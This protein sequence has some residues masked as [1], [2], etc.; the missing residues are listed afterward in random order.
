MTTET[1]SPPPRSAFVTVLAWTII[2][3]SA[4]VVPVSAIALLMILARSYGTDATDVAG[5]LSVVVAPPAALLAG[6]GL[7]RRR[8]WAWWA[9]AALLLLLIAANGQALLTAHGTTTTRRTADGVET[10]EMPPAPNRPSAPI[11]AVC[12]FVLVGLCSR[13]V[14]AELGVARWPGRAAAPAPAPIDAPA[15]DWRDWR[16]GHRGRDGMYYEERGAAGWRRI[17]IDGEML[18]GRTHHVIYFA[19]P[20]RWRRY[21]AWARDR[22]DEI[23]ARIKSEF[24]PPD[25]EY[26]GDGPGRAVAPAAGFAPRAARGGAPAR[27]RG[28]LL[29]AVGLLLGLGAGAG[30]MAARGVRQGATWWPAPRVT[31]QRVVSRQ[32]EPA[33]FWLSIGVYAL[34]GVGSSGLALWGLRTGWRG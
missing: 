34:V 22:R 6:I 27:Q 3:A 7:L 1:S 24:R 9:V 20:D 30:W 21:P 23:I 11:I 26:S 28:A 14:R 8:T 2:I 33:S 16:V 25:Y 17:E 12:V 32:E 29:L 5:F 15:T 19:S 10:T 4:C 18:M 13:A 31:Q